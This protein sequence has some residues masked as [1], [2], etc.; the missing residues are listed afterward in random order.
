MTRSPKV[1][2]VMSVYNHEAFVEDAIRSVLD[3]KFQ[4]YEFLI[5]DDA[6]T[7]L[8]LSLV[9][10][11]AS[12]DSRI[13]VLRNECRLGLTKSLNRAIR[14]ASGDWIARQD[15]DDVSITSRLEI[16][17]RHLEANP[18]LG[19]IGS[20]YEGID[21]QARHLYYFVLPTADEE[22]KKW[23]KNIN[24]F[25]HGSVMFSKKVFTRI[26][27]YPEQYPF[28]QDYALWLRFR[29]L[30]GMENV[31]EFLYQRRIHPGAIS[32]INQ[33]RWIV[34][35]RLK[36]DAGL[37]NEYLPLKRF[38]AN[39]YEIHGKFLMKMGQHKMGIMSLLRG[40]LYPYL[41]H[42]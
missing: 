38:I 41:I 37:T 32:K 25:C 7:D 17:L 1:S 14:L 11:W 3:Q 23:L 5:A 28:A 27:G 19:L 6:S 12:Y 30:I 39:E 31:S 34:L 22:L 33:E 8:S 40:L 21:E 29:S 20:F 16:Q 13:R 2:V 9:K 26:G 18:E 35:Q 24:C 10:K 36:F 42:L 15:A 4:D